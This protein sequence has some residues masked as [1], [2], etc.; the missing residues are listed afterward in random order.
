MT[1]DSLRDRWDAIR[2]RVDSACHDAGRD[3]AEVTVIVVT[4]FF[5]ASDV[6]RLAALGVRDMGAHPRVGGAD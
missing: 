5:P 2:G 1:A 4:K 6:R 3:P